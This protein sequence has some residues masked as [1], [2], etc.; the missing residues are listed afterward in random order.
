MIR[1]QESRTYLKFLD[2]L[3][4]LNPTLTNGR[5]TPLRI[6]LQT[7]NALLSGSTT[8]PRD[9][10]YQ[11]EKIMAGLFVIC[12]VLVSKSFT[13]NAGGEQ[14]DAAYELDG[15]YY[16]V[17]CKWWKKKVS[18]SDIAELLGKVRLSGARTMGLF[19]AVNGWSS[20]VVPLLKQDPDKKVLLMNGEDIHAALE[21]K[22]SLV[23]MLRAKAEALNVKAEPFL[24]VRDISTKQPASERPEQVRSNAT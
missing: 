20:H 14:I 12:D 13:R 21:G 11:L 2:Q 24:S 17:E 8:N 19:V 18:R 7:Y 4:E 1:G 9:R 6:L 23:D 3:G 15:S 5:G 16:L 10:G 22:I